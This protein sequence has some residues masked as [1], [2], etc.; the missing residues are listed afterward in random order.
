MDVLS[1]K[2]RIRAL[3]NIGDWQL[4][5]GRDAVM[6]SF[7]FND[8]NEAFTFMKKVAELAEQANHHPEWFNIY[9]RVDITLSTHDAGGLTMRDINLATEID[10]LFDGD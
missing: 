1:G 6:R 10:T 7:K 5:E 9:N 4:V 8:F 3:A 2:E